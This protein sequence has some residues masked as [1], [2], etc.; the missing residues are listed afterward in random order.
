MSNR[1]PNILK[2]NMNVLNNPNKRQRLSDWKKKV[3]T[4]Y[5]IQN[6]YFRFKGKQI[7][8][9]RIGIYIPCKQQPRESWRDY[10]NVR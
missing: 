6:T 10:V 3:S 7:E 1:I 2:I 9:K 5:C 8:I 4:I